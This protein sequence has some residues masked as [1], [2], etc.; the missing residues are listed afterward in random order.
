MKKLSLF[1]STAALALSAGTAFAADIVSVEFTDTPAPTE[2]VEMVTTHSKSSAIVRYSDGTTKEFPLSYVS[3]FK[4]TDAVGADTAAGQLFN[5]EGEPLTDMNGDPIIAETPD[6][7]SLLN[8][9]GNLFMVTHY[10]YDWILGNGAEARRTE[11][12]Y[13]RMPMSM[14]LAAVEQDAD[15]TL[16]A[17][18]VKPIDFSGVDGLWIPCAGGPTPWNTHLGS[19]ED[20]D[21][22]YQAVS[23]EKNLQRATEGLRALS[24]MYLDGEEANPYHYGFIPE[25]T[26]KADGSTEVVK[27]YSMGRATWEMA[28]VMADSRTVY[29]G[30][31]G[32]YVAMFMY[33]ADTAEDLSAG[34]LYAARWNQVSSQGGG[35]ATLDWVKLGHATDA[36]VRAIIDSGV[37][38]DDIFDSTTAEA[39]PDWEAQGYRMIRAG[40]SG[41]EILRLK[42]GMEQAAAFLESRRYAGYLG[43]TTEFNKM[44]ALDADPKKKNLYLAISYSEKGMQTEEGA[45]QDHIQIDKT[46]AGATY[47]IAM[48]GGRVDMN[49]EPINSD[50]VGTAMRVPAALLGEDIPVDALGNIA[51]PDK[52][53]NP[54]NVFFSNEMRTLFIGEDSGTHVNNFVWAYNVDTGKLSRILSQASGAEATGLQVVDNIGDHAYIMSNNQHQGEWISSMPEDLVAELEAAATEL[55]GTNDKGTMN[56]KLEAHIGYL[57]GMPGL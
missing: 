39:T 23:G 6:A 7:N 25:V 13:S 22:Y 18:S 9:D 45:P 36:E 8:V 57:G 16:T 4:N 32:A 2:A 17:T 55:Y 54:D 10:E 44:E 26:V 53:A 50:F 24:E 27:H 11:G 41:D 49:G 19:E 20:Y 40:H 33:V 38:F 42:D 48:D 30:D 12:W 14:S 1:C 3:M 31:D 51:N 29:F 47:E 15:G 56:Y 21:L 28:R 43:A 34:A 46:K 52:I 35:S 5:A 37:T